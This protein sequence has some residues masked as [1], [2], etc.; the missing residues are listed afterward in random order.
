MKIECIL[1]KFKWI[2]NY[3]KN[4]NIIII[5]VGKSPIIMEVLDERK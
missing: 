4:T 1:S 2:F 5:V 3:I